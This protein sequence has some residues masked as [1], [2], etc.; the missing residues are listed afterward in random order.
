MGLCPSDLRDI[1]WAFSSDM[2]WIA[3]PCASQLS[4]NR[5]DR[6]RVSQMNHI[7]TIEKSVELLKDDD[8]SPIAQQGI[9]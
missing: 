2:I 3:W 1:L 8:N 6:L 9:S 4:V 7:S 5:G